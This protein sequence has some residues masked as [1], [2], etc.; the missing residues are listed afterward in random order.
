MQYAP[1]SLLSVSTFNNKITDQ[2]G[3]GC[4]CN[5]G[6]GYSGFVCS[7][8]FMQSAGGPDVHSRGGVSGTGVSFGLPVGPAVG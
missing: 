2:D 8:L 7:G 4:N 6:N 1:L 3:S 5:I